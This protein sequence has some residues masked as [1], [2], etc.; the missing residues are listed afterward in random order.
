[1]GQKV[2]CDHCGLGCAKASPQCENTFLSSPGVSEV[3]V[4]VLGLKEVTVVC[5]VGSLTKGF[6]GLVAK[7]HRYSR[8]NTTRQLVQ[9]RRLVGTKAGTIKPPMQQFMSRT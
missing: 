5:E 1:M 7:I 9:K 2:N 8:R 6:T 3:Q 4:H